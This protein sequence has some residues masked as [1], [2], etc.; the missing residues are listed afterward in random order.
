MGTTEIT[1]DA[2][3]TA[4]AVE[5]VVVEA[6]AVRITVAVTTDE[7]RRSFTCSFYCLKNAL[8]TLVQVQTD[9]QKLFLFWPDGFHVFHLVATCEQD[10]AEIFTY[11]TTVFSWL[12]FLETGY[13]MTKG[14]T[15]RGTRNDKTHIISR[16]SGRRVYHLQKKRDSVR[17]RF[18]WSKKAKRRTAP[19]TGRARH[20]KDVNRRFQWVIFLN[21]GTT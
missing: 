16:I 4:V 9:F 3:I 20:L 7:N 8:L 13:K 14:T 21:K 10:L 18:N 1:V 5:A 11:S 17:G 19:G 15:S 12:F 2:V 6:T